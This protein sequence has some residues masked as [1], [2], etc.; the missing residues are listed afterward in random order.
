MANPEEGQFGF[1]AKGKDWTAS[2][3]NR[4]IRQLEKQL[5]KPIAKLLG[6]MAGGASID[7]HLAVLAVALRQHHKAEE[8]S[9]EDV[10][11]L[12]RPGDLF[13][14][15]NGLVEVTFMRDEGGPPLKPD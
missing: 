14:V 12:L 2:L 3:S 10:V 15:V 11:D 9:D 5:K 8:I 4:A 7:D 13:R 1:K 6:D